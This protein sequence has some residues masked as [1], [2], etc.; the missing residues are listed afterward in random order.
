MLPDSI[1]LIVVT[2]ERQLLRESVVEVTMPGLDGQ[3]GMV[4][5]T[6]LSRSSCRSG[7]TTINWMESGSIR[8]LDTRFHLLGLF[9]NLIDCADHVK[10]LLRNF[11]VFTFH[12]FLEAPD[13]V[14]DLDVLAFEAG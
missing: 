8:D 6:T 3:L 5:S 4:T 9:E 14:F 7:V 12:D 13:G 1:Q 10:R 11:V 2:P